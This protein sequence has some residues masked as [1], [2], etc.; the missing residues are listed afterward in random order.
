MFRRKL[1]SEAID[2]SRGHF[3]CPRCNNVRPYQLKRASVDFTFYFVPLF[4]TGELEEFVVCQLCNKGY[5][6]KVLDQFNQHLFRLTWVAK[7]E[8]VHNTP[9]LLKTKLLQ[10]GLKEA[11]IDKLIIL[12]QN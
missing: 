2:R 10:N 1:K 11:F 12:A 7:R 8:L 3:F 9:E 4:E 5:D 6:P